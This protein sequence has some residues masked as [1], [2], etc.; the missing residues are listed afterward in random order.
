[1]LEPSDVSDLVEQHDLYFE[2]RRDELRELRRLYMTRFWSNEAQNALDGILRHLSKVELE[3]SG[4]GQLR[5][6]S[7]LARAALIGARA[8]VVVVVGR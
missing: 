4:A 8:V 5:H 1:M 3:A 2:G 7:W 6:G